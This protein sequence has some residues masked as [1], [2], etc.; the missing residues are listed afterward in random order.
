MAQQRE[1]LAALA[2]LAISETIELMETC[3]TLVLA[4]VRYD[5][6]DPA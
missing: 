6:C 2:G 1:S 4:A 5:G 3:I